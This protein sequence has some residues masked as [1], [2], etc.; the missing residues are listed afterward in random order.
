MFPASRCI[1]LSCPA[2]PRHP[3]QMALS[4]LP[5]CLVLLVA[6]VLVSALLHQVLDN[7]NCRRCGGSGAAVLVAAA[8]FTK[9]GAWQSGPEQGGRGRGCRLD[10]PSGN[11]APEPAPLTVAPHRRPVQRAVVPLR[12]DWRGHRL[13]HTVGFHLATLTGPLV[14]WWVCQAALLPSRWRAGACNALA[15]PSPPRPL[16]MSTAFTSAPCSTRYLTVWKWPLWAQ[17]ISGVSPIC[18]GGHRA[19]GGGRG[20]RAAGAGEARGAVARRGRW[21]RAV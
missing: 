18:G 20:G 17:R 21:H 7:L 11:P 14:G 10:A 4:H 9:R 16:T 3:S 12:T 6:Q 19:Q 5:A 2:T 15:L 13:T 1:K 8:H